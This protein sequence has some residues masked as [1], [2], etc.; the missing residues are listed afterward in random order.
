MRESI[1]I[2]NNRSV[3]DLKVKRRI[4]ELPAQILKTIRIFLH[5][6]NAHIKQVDF[7]F[8]FI[9]RISGRNTFFFLFCVNNTFSQ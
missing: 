8:T 1:L 6:S 7:N 9:A 3:P 4:R 5:F 2:R